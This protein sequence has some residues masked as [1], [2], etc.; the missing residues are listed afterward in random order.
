MHVCTVGGT[1]GPRTRCSQ[2]QAK[3]FYP[4]RGKHVGNKNN[5]GK[6][7]P[8]NDHG[9]KGR[10]RQAF[11]ILQLFKVVGARCLKVRR[12]V[13]VKLRFSRTSVAT[14][15][16]PADAVYELLLYDVLVKVRGR[17]P[18]VTNGGETSERSLVY[19]TNRNQ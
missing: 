1:G 11:G 2:C 13:S 19:E 4:K 18:T 15:R 16:D 6:S 5:D 10:L 9:V 17:H 12:A 14:C 3:Y 7:P 8:M